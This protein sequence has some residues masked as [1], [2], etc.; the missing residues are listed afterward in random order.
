M[1]LFLSSFFA[2]VADLFAEFTACAGKKVVFIPT[3]SNVEKITF[4]IAS[5]KK[6]LQKLGM[7][8]DE[9]D[10][11]TA[12]QET[13]LNKISECDYIFVEG[14][15]TFFLLQEMKRSGADKII[16]DQILSGKIYIGASAGSIIV[17]KNIEYVK[18]LDNPDAAPDL[19]GDF[20]ALGLVDFCIVPHFANPPFK[21]AGEAIVKAYSDKLNLRPIGNNQAVVV[22]GDRAET[23]TA[24]RKM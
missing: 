16:S 12:P 20:S 21:K 24:V 15:N 14:G 6:A 2:G 22:N 7:L 5:D 8:I 13:V 1:K 17:S 11:A 19:S 3:A 23:L 18:H 9:L 10:I 4:Y